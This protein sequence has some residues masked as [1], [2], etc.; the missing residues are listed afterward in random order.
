M[1]NNVL[2]P[3]NAAD[4]PEQLGTK[5]KFWYQS[6]DGSQWLFKQ[7]RPNTGENWAEKVASELCKLLALPAAHYEFASFGEKQG[8]ISELFV[9]AGGRLILGNELLARIIPGYDVTKR[10]VAK[11]HRLPYVLGILR[12]PR[13][14]LPIGFTAPLGIVNAADVFVGYIMLDAWIGNQDRHH[15]NWGLILG[16]SDRQVSL[17][18]TYDHASSLG[19]N[20]PDAKRQDML[21]T[22]DR[23]RNIQ[24]Y[25]ARANSAFYSAHTAQD[26]AK[27]KPLSTLDAFIEARKVHSVASTYW[28]AKLEKITENELRN[29]FLEIPEDRIT[30]TASEFALEVLKEN[31]ARLLGCV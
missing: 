3:L 1:F 5:Y 19:R 21:T 9:P 12:M 18:P 20:E 24:S 11:Q 7:G 17:A 31:R 15:E 26:A 25:V 22:K 8:V 2:V 28:L 16:G 10:Y 14:N 13:I 4:L 29:I 23:G 27:V 30:A 6:G